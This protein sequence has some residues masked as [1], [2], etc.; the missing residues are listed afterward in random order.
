MLP[1]RTIPEPAA[2]W[3]HRLGLFALALALVTYVLHRV[4]HLTT[5]IALNTGAFALGIAALAVLIGIWAI[6]SIWVLGRSGFHAALVGVI[7]AT[8][9]WLVPLAA[10]P[11]ISSLPALTDISTDPVNPPPFGPIA[12]QRG[13]GSN[14]TVWAG[15]RTAPIQARSYPDLRTLTVERGLDETFDLVLATVRG[16]RGLGWRVVTQEPPA[17]GRPGII[18][19]S[20]RTLLVGFTDDVV[21]RVAGR[22]GAVAVDV[23]SASRYGRHDLGAN[24]SRIRRFMREFQARLDA[25]LPGSP[26]ARLRTSGADAS[27]LK[28]P[29]ARSPGSKD[30][31]GAAA[32]APRDA[33]RA[34]AP[35]AQPRG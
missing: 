31:K 25:T 1:G 27:T 35:K 11:A 15:P 14:S 4:G 33:R 17:G 22:D 29:L 6:G 8:L 24:A 30:E 13:P 12:K 21:I 3:S 26:G 34:P 23:R 32:P 5:P 10:L 9:P 2:L 28:R 19:A 16:R 20:E 7:A 18:E